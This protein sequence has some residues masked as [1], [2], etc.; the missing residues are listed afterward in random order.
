MLLSSVMC[1]KPLRH[2]NV[3]IKLYINQ[4]YSSGIHFAKELNKIYLNN[5]IKKKTG[6]T[7]L[8]GSRVT[9]IGRLYRETD[10]VLK[11]LLI[12]IKY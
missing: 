9:V 12:L 10:T 3:N 8:S 7:S 2:R 5:I 4:N 6:G 11:K 1:V